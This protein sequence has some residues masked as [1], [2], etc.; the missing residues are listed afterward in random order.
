MRVFFAELAEAGLFAL[1]LLLEPCVVLVLTF[2]VGGCV[3]VGGL[4]LEVDGSAFDTVGLCVGVTVRDEPAICRGVGV[5]IRLLK[6]EDL[7]ASTSVVGVSLR[8]RD[9]GGEAVAASR[10]KDSVFS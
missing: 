1:R 2:K 3:A 4:T 6:L 8:S 5:G 7:D 9:S 10:P